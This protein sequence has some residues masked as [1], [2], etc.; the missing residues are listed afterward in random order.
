MSV[1]TIRNSSSACAFPMLELSDIIYHRETGRTFLTEP[2]ESG[3]LGVAACFL[4]RASPASF[5][6]ECLGRPFVV[7]GSGPGHRGRCTAPNCLSLRQSTSNIRL[8]VEFLNKEGE[9]IHSVQPQFS[10]FPALGREGSRSAPKGQE[11][12]F[13]NYCVGEQSIFFTTNKTELGVSRVPYDMLVFPPAGTRV[14]GILNVI[15][16][17]DAISRIGS[18][19]AGIKKGL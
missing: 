15:L 16:P 3:Q 19:R 14:N 5:A 18:I 10:G 12:A 4:T 17:N 6:T 11:P 13:F 7:A 8:L 2:P 1:R 9:V